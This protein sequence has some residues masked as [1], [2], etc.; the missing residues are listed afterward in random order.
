MT[1]RE[2]QTPFGYIEALRNGERIAFAIEKAA[3]DSYYI[4][5]AETEIV[6]PLGC[7]CI[8]VDIREMQRGDHVVVRYS[9][10][11]L[12]GDGG[13]ERKMNA[14]AEIDGFTIA[15]GC[16]DTED[17]E[18]EWSYYKRRDASRNGYEGNRCLPYEV[19]GLSDGGY[20]FEIIDSP[21]NY[22]AYHSEYRKCTEIQIIA[23]W[24]NNEK[25][26]AWE[27][28]SFLTC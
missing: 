16:E 9:T 1:T 20:A 22:L 23:A 19:S 3:D 24:E 13:G 14:V 11:H 27:I 25:S 21:Q 5:D 12:F 7:Y 4:D 2:F 6:H 8:T 26:Y 18:R 28:V 15:M 10:G 17:I